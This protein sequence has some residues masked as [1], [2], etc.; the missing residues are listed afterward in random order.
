MDYYGRRWVDDDAVVLI[1]PGIWHKLRRAAWRF[2]WGH[3][4]DWD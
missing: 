3:D 2:F 1:I 4:E